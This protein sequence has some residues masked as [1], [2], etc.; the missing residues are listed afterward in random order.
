MARLADSSERRVRITLRCLVEDLGLEVP[1]IDRPIGLIDHPMLDEARRVAPSSPQGQKRILSIRRPPVYRLRHSTDRGATWLDEEE[2]I[3][4][5]VAVARREDQSENDAFAVFARLHQAGRLLPSDDDRC[6]IE[7][8]QGAELL[9][10]VRRDIV[11]LLAAAREAP[12]TDAGLDLA[13]FVPARAQSM[14]AAGI[15]ELWMAVSTRDAAG[16]GVPVRLR[17]MI[18]AIAEQ[19]LVPA[20]WEPRADWPGGR[21]EWFEVCRL[22]IR[23][24]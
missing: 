16:E 18:F 9:A 7:F 3:L 6:R 4:W 19:L 5:L 12:G 10:R 21:L 1:G 24:S 13:G 23:A 2:N 8:E 22:A 20:E 15:E 11:P 17:D 14:R